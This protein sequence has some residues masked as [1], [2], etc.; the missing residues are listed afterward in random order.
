MKWAGL[1][2][3][4]AV[5]SAL[6]DVVMLFLQ[7]PNWRAELDHNWNDMPPLTALGVPLA[8]AALAV[9]ANPVPLLGLLRRARNAREREG[10]RAFALMVGAVLMVGTAA[11]LAVHLFRPV[12]VDRYLFAVPV[13]VA[14]L[15]ALPAAR[16]AADRRLLGLL[17]LVSVAVPAVTMLVS[18]GK[19]LWRENAQT[20]AT[21]VADCAATQGYA[22]SGRALGP[23]AE[24]HAARREDVGF[25]RACRLLPDE[26]RYPVRFL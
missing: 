5:A 22:A 26:D 19:P 20:I 15:L 8:L 10:E 17:A 21:I 7:A 23:V 14:A 12:V 11:I 9:C 24:T 18:G 6:F 1:I 16:F 2:V 3:V 13:L 4:A 25:E